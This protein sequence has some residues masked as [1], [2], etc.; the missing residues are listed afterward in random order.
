MVPPHSINTNQP[1]EV[2]DAVKAAFAEMGGEP[3]FPLLDQ[4]FSDVSAMFQGRY[5]GYQA[6][7]MEYHD[8]DHTLQATV[9]LTHLL[10]GRSRTSDQPVLGIRDWELSVMSVLL[11][12]TG[13]LKRVGDESGTGAKYTFVHEQRSCDFAREYLSRLGLNSEEVNDVCSAI[14]CTGPRSKISELTF[15]REEARQMAFILVTADY[16]AQI[17]AADYLEKLPGLYLEFEESYDYN[18]VPIEERPYQNFKKLLEKTPGF[19]YGYVLPLLNDKVGGVCHYLSEPG[20]PNPYF[21][22]V[23]ANLVELQRRLA[24][25]EI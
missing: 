14:I 7:D 5:P 12:D 13:F 20:Q 21:V 22:S 18:K 1:S 24:A 11:H 9:C 2:A 25:G 8:F 17:S 15:R 19:W 23:N 3:S 16:L 10:R 4:L 6:I